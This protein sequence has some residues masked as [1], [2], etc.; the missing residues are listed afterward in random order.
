MMNRTMISTAF[1][2][3]L[4]LGG[5][6]TAAT[7]SVADD[8]R[9]AQSTKIS[10]KQAITIASTQASGSLISA[11]FDEDDD[12]AKGG[13]Y[14]IEFH[15]D[16]TGYDIKVDATTGKI[17]RTET[18]R[19]DR[20]DINEYK[21]QQKAKINIIDA[22]SIAEKNTKGRI[23]KIEFKN[24]RD[25]V[26]HSTYYEAEV[27]KGNQIHELNIDANTGRVFDKKVKR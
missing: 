27:L 13:V 19:L 8:V 24:D 9:A 16:M 10:L 21:I 5:V 12:R 14:E 3:M 20:D 26:D 1:A 7:A 15:S 11:E 22:M 18:E 4:L 2:T 6:S 23:I 17:I 25:Y